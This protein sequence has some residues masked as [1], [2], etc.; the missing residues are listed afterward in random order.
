MKFLLRCAAVA[1][2]TA[3]I[4]VAMPTL[5]AEHATKEEAVA[6]VKKANAYMKANGPEKAFAAFADPNGG[7][8]KGEL[9]IIC[10][11]KAGTMKSH[12]NPKMVGQSFIN[13]VDSDGFNFTKA[14]IEKGAGGGSG[15][16]DYKFSN[17]VTHKIEPKS[18]Y[19]EGVGDIA[20]GAG[21]YR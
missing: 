8:V 3:V 10:L 16:V 12:P 11:D 9:Y 4:S 20:I 5:R 1:A 2:A 21:I 6:L 19:V 14:I 18:T 7:Y 17:P 15:W 13:L